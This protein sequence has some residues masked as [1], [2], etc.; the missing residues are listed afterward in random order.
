MMRMKTKGDLQAQF[1]KKNSK[2]TADGMKKGVC[3]VVFLLSLL[4]CIKTVW[5]SLD[6]DE[7]YALAVAYR[8]ANG[9]KLFL[10][11]WESHQLGGIFLAPFVWIYLR[12]AGTTEYMV[13]Y[14]RLIGTLIHIFA[15]VFL[16][17][18]AYRAGGMPRSFSL[19]LFFLHL[20]FLPKWVQCPEFELQ[21]YWFILLTFLC[22]YRYYKGNC[23]KKRYLVFSG[24]MLLGQMLSYVSL[25]F[26]YPVYAAGICLS[27]RECFLK[28]G[29]FTAR[30]KRVFNG[31][32]DLLFFTLGAAVPGFLFLAYLRS[33]LTPAELIKYI[34]YIFQDE[35]HTLLSPGY[36]WLFFGRDFLK[37]L[38]PMLL[39]MGISLGIGFGAVRGF[40]RETQTGKERLRKGILFSV[41]VYFVLLSIMQ[42]T[43]CLLGDQNQFYMMWR[44]FAAAL[45]GTAVFVTGRTKED[46]LCFRFGILPGFVTLLSV[47]IM[48]NMDINTSM[49]KMYICVIAAVW[50]SGQKCYGDKR[51]TDQ[52]ERDQKERDQKAGECFLWIGV[53]SLT[54]GLLVCKLIQ[55]RVSGCRE[56]TVIAPME[57]I[58][59][60]PAKGIFMLE[61]TAQILNDDYRVLT[62]FLTKEDKLLYVGSE[63][64][65]YLWTEAA[66]ATPS[67]Q[68]TNAYNEMFVHYYEEHPEKLPTVIVID[69]ELGVNPAYY[70]SPWN[71]ILYEWMDEMGYREIKES[72]HLRILR[73]EYRNGDL[74]GISES[75]ALF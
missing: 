5:I 74:Y 31:K 72:D 42:I 46:R 30:G 1:H 40:S 54:A 8:L 52:K 45:A 23:L 21:Q 63:N 15:G 44:F 67:T 7:C 60:G 6:I 39:S 69:K 57:Q 32:A 26:L 49:A 66:V 13:I 36:K 53:L 19:L 11:L 22:L 12:L 64:I 10:D 2:I 59:E 14:T 4:A 18:T 33:Y 43:G 3:L 28:E 35:S 61:E 48:T 65:V 27:D 9:E 75:D 73:N 51:E 55:M 56:V 17:R 71:Y 24:M 29:D 47:L 37:M 68:G 50:M 16:Y 38:P 58:A 62:D 25:I 41:P 34:N 70:N 20:N